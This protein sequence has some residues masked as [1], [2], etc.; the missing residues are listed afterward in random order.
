MSAISYAALKRKGKGKR[1]R[2]PAGILHVESFSLW[3]EICHK[4][5]KTVQPFDIKIVAVVVYVAVT[6]SW[7]IS[8]NSNK[9]KALPLPQP[10]DCFRGARCSHAASVIPNVTVNLLLQSWSLSLMSVYFALKYFCKYKQILIL[11]ILYCWDRDAVCE[12]QDITLFLWKKYFMPLTAMP[13]FYYSV[14]LVIVALK[15]TLW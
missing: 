7:Q 1:K 3:S 11:L 12:Q 9:M 14:L 5:D 15:N 13:N 10:F 6:R 2:I 8:C 4:S